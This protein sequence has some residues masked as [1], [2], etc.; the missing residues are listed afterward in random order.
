MAVSRSRRKLWRKSRVS[1]DRCRRRGKTQTSLTF[2]LWPM[3]STTATT[4]VPSRTAPGI[5]RVH[6]CV[7]VC[8][9][10]DERV[11]PFLAAELFRA[12]V[13]TGG[14]APAQPSVKIKT[15]TVNSFVQHSSSNLTRVRFFSIIINDDGARR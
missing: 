15:Q 9:G 8:S 14:W 11:F 4:T 13:E 10:E 6:S 1:S 7:R 2:H 3:M 12:S 5:V